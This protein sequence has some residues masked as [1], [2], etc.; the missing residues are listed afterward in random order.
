M[1]VSPVPQSIRR[2]QF[3]VLTL[4]GV[5]L[6]TQ[7]SPFAHDGL[8]E[9]IARVSAQ[10]VRAPANPEL[11]V[12]RA[13]LYRAARQYQQ[14]LA[15]LDRASGLNPA[16]ESADLARAHLFLDMG[17]AQPAVDAA[18]RFLQ[19]RPGHAGAL[20][21]RGRARAKLGNARTAASD[22]ARALDTS[23]IPDLYIERARATVASGGAGIEEALRGLD[24]GI[25]RLGPLVTLELEAIDLELQLARYDRALMRLDRVSA[26]SPRKESWLA[27][28][29]EILESAGRIAQ[30]RANYHAALAAAL[31]LPAWIQRT[32]AS[33]ALIE[34]L[35]TSLGRLENASPDLP[36]RHGKGML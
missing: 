23:P 24:E 35:R 6:S 28:R 11:L 25:A 36:E 27:R 4:T 14:A 20:I 31:S 12:T 1:K 16:I 19:R 15:D 26:Q 22:F 18:S 29:G 3:A 33:S 10:I 17:N 7:Q 9:Q 30:A 2:R 5:L 8:A 13:E 32:Q 21:I 34:R